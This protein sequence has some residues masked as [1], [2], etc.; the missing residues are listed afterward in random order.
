MPSEPSE[1]GQFMKGAIGPV[2]PEL[3]AAYRWAPNYP[4]NRWTLPLVRLLLKA[5]AARQRPVDGVE[6]REF[7]GDGAHVRV[8]QGSRQSR[9][10]PAALLWFP[11]SIGFC[12]GT[13]SMDDARCSA[14]ALDLG[15]T[16]CA[17]DYRLA[18]E[19]PFP[20]ALED[21][22]AAWNWLQRNADRLDVDPERVG[23][24]GGTSGG[25]LAASLAQRLRDHAGVQPAA[26]VLVF[27]MLDDRPRARHELDRVPYKVTGN[28]FL[29]FAWSSYLGTSAGAAQLPDYAVPARCSDLRAL[30]PTWIGV[31]TLDPLLAENL[32]Y[33]RR[34]RE[35]DVPTHL[36]VVDGAPAVFTTQAPH[37][38]V[39][40][41]FLESSAE[42]VRRELDL[43]P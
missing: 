2:H 26:Q 31:G 38:D 20:A 4:V 3:A 39:T 41:Q 29:R 37:A 32:D 12:A 27:P 35:A 7:S 19:H 34:L 6:V 30:P 1:H 15:I 17:A 13:L 18:P 11:G 40:R 22:H 21:C 8:Y 36:E 28:S 25:T 9:P 14:T 33:A 16:V 42:H 10:E 43:K 23:L 24:I 5:W